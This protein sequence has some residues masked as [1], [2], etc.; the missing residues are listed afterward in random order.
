MEARHPANHSFL[1]AGCQSVT[2]YT[3]VFW[4]GTF[5]IPMRNQPW[6][7]WR[8][9][10]WNP[11]IL[12]H[13]I[14]LPKGVTDTLIIP[15]SNT[16]I[17]QCWKSSNLQKAKSIKKYQEALHNRFR[18]P[19]DTLESWF[20]HHFHILPNLRK[21]SDL[22]IIPSIPLWPADSMAPSQASQLCMEPLCAARRQRHRVVRRL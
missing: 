19:L 20:P 4:I 1:R 16:L 22:P 7:F 12:W 14:S 17:H 21:V 2:S 3:R 11:Y 8:D 13:N 15:F 5:R 9:Q 18:I 6:D 10:S